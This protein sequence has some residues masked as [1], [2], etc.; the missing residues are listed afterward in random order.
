M[1]AKKLPIR[2]CVACNLPQ[3]KRDLLRVVR[4]VD[5]TVIVDRKGKISGRGAYVC[6][7]PSCIQQALKSRRLE[8]QLEVSISQELI[9][10]LQSIVEG[11][12]LHE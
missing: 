4:K 8:R 7:K 12:R 3:P 10:E 11:D 1:K 9:E 2:T 6:P 5:G